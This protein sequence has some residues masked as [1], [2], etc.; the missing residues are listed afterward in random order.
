MFP[1]NP[2]TRAYKILNILRNLGK[3]KLKYGSY[4]DFYDIFKMHIIIKVK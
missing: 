1:N 3:D 4:K 2:V